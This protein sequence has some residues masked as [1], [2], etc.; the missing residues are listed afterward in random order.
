M[1]LEKWEKRLPEEANLFNPA[2]MGSLAYEFVKEFQ[3]TK[4][5]GAPLTYLPITLA[6]ALHKPTRLRM[7]SSTITSMFE[8]VQENEDILIG[9][10]DRVNGL[11]PY[12]REAITFSIKQNSLK[13]GEGHFLITDNH[14]AHFS[15]PF[16]REAT[17]EVLEA[18]D[19]TKFVARWF[20]K[21]GSE[22]SILA[23]WGIKP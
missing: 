9:L 19:K 15:A 13:F 3:K 10:S 1:A 14:K 5:E 22:S 4:L 2:F 20:L 12:I 7:P 23:C 17:Q 11:L 6:V 16:K 8:W 21:S 18:I